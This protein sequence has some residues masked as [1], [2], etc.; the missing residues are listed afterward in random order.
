MEERKRQSDLCRQF[1]TNKDLKEAGTLSSSTLIILCGDMNFKSTIE[2]DNLTPRYFQDTITITQMN[3][4][5]DSQHS[6]TIGITYPVQAHNPRRSDFV[7]F[8]GEGWECTRHI[9]L[10]NDPI[11]DS[12]GHEIPCK[13]GRDGYLYPSDHL[14]ILTRFKRAS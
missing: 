13:R 4:A 6:A 7:L 3:F 9:H 11:R 5:V 8:R 14:G 1:L 2:L 10:A 12:N